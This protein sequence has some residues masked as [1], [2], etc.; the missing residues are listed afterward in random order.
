MFAGEMEGFVLFC[1]VFVEITPSSTPF[2][3]NGLVKKGKDSQVE[4]SW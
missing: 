2:V 1:F 4:S 3:G